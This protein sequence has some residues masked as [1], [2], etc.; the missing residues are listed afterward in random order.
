M[1]KTVII[2]NLGQDAQ[3]KTTQQGQAFSSFTVAV[4]EKRN[5]QETTTTWFSCSGWGERFTG[6]LVQYLKK[7]TKVYLEGNY[8]PAIYQRNDG[9]SDI[10]HNFMVNHIELLGGGQQSTG[11]QAAA[12]APQGFPPAQHAAQ[13]PQG[14]PPAQHAAPA[15]QGFPPAQDMPFPNQQQRAAEPMN[16]SQRLAQQQP[17]PSTPGS[18]HSDDDLPF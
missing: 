9:T 8:S 11:Q 7:G 2:G 4:S 15:A 16:T 14:F 6:S 5:G 17:F 3:V 1:K 12:P 18:G 10:S 13:A